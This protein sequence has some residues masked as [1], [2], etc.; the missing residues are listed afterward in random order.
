MNATT[1]EM[2]D[3]ERVTVWPDGTTEATYTRTVRI[4]VTR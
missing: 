3:E 4:E 1:V 2:T